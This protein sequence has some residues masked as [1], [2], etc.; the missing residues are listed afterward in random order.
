MA[1]SQIGIFQFIRFLAARKMYL[2]IV[3]WSLKTN[4]DI[5]IYRFAKLSLL[6]MTMMFTAE[7]VRFQ[8]SFQD[9]NRVIIGTVYTCFAT[10]TLSSTSTLENVTGSHRAGLNHDDVKMVTIFR[11]NIS[12]IPEGITNF[13]RNLIALRYESSPLRSISSQDLQP[14]PQLQF[15][16][17]TSGNLINLDDDLF[18]FTPNLHLLHFADNRI[19]HIGTN[20]M[21]NLSHLSWLGLL[22]NVCVSRGSSTRAGVLQLIP[23]L[24][25]LC[26]LDIVTTQTSTTEREIEQCLCDREIL[27]LE[28][29]IDR[30]EKS[31]DALQQS[32][33]KLLSL[34]ATFEQRLEDVEMQLRELQSAPC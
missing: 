1:H 8:C 19:R 14:F 4:Q 22:D 29:R 21:A 18:F 20:S 27:E 11:Q 26:P 2:Q 6:F 13:F 31:N 16:E 33:E 28:I 17:V 5:F 32:N 12:F 30:L 34:T 7:A 9:N 10:V 23:Q 15:L 25:R 24:S 3:F